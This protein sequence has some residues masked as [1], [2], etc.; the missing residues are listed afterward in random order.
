MNVALFLRV[1]TTGQT[2]ENQLRELTE[3]CKRNNWEIVEQYDETVSGTKG[4][5]ERSELNRML[6]DASRRKFEKVVVWSVDRLGR[7]MKHL[8][9]VLSQLKDSGINLYSYKQGI[10]TS[11]TMG[12]SFFYMIGIFAEL[13][14]NMRKERQV[15]GIKRALA[16]GA[17]FGRKSKL[18]KNIRA[19]IETLRS[20]GLAMRKIAKQLNI[21]VATVHKACSEKVAEN[22]TSQAA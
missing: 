8:V 20:E 22:G 14:N 7:N 17:K 21:S 15:A 18:S 4:V 16:N 13:E 5:N 11:T 9:S 3:V 10:D 1:S 6:K 19:E 12:E 2:T